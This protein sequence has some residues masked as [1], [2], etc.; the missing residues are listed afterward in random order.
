METDRRYCHNAIGV[1]GQRQ[2][3]ENHGCRPETFE[4]VQDKAKARRITTYM[5]LSAGAFKVYS[6]PKP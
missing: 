5:Y 3:Q 1:M 4:I 6:A 2:R